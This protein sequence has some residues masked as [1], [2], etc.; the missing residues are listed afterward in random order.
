M[1]QIAMLD[2]K[3][4]QRDGKLMTGC[5]CGD[6][7]GCQVFKVTLTGSI[8]ID[9]VP[10]CCGSG[11]NPPDYTF[12]GTYKVNSDGVW[13]TQLGT[14]GN[15]T[16]DAVVESYPDERSVVFAVRWYPGGCSSIDAEWLKFYAQDGLCGIYQNYWT[17]AVCGSYSFSEDF[18][19][20]LTCESYG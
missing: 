5:C 14:D 7:A 17:N 10:Y 15:L 4:L 12:S 11:A 8:H 2:G 20:R 18:S 3:L 13:R 16:Y 6:C 1:T 19:V 9:V